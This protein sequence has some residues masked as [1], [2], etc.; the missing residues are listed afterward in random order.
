ML[1]LALAAAV[2]QPQPGAL[3]TFGDWT[4]GCD[5]VATCKAVALIPGAQGDTPWLRLA[6]RRDGAPAAK[7]VLRVGLDDGAPGPLALRVDGRSI[8]AVAAGRDAPLDRAA[9]G[10]LAQGATA[11]VVDARGRTVAS[12]SLKGLAAALLYVD[13]RQ[14]RLGTAG[15]L[16]RRGPRADAAVP[17]PPPLPRVVR[18]AASAAPPRRPGEAALRRLLGPDAV[19]CAEGREPLGARAIRLD[20]ARSLSLVAWP[21]SGGAYNTVHGAFVVD[22]R[23]RAAPAVFDV[24]GGMNPDRDDLVNADWDA[25]R[26]LLTTLAKGRGLGDC[27]VSQAYAWDGARFRLVEQRVMNECRGSIDFVTTWRA[28]VVA[29]R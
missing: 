3:R 7:P 2:V 18:P 24:D 11:A 19:D 5:N 6:V 28:A 27:G 21:C 13:E 14:R 20:A 23:G 17:A 8:V 15:A 26:R 16:V 12:T 29:G 9:S 1:L 10:A 25:G 22:E 4:V